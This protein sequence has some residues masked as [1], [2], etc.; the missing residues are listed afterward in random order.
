MVP[1]DKCKFDSRGRVIAGGLFS[2]PHK[3]DFDRL[4]ND[5]RPF[6]AIEGRLNWAKL[7]HGTQL[8]LLIVQSGEAVRGSGDDLSSYFHILKHLDEWVCRNVV[9]SPLTAPRMSHLVVFLGK[10]ICWDL[11]RFVW[12]IAT[13]WIS[14]R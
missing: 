10:R 14:P 5:R 7:P 11:S 3:A 9:G 12:G 1:L 4:I 8:T 2:V 13:P 6:N